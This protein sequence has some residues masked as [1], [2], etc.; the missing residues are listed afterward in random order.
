MRVWGVFFALWCLLAPAVFPASEK[1]PH[2]LYDAIKALR[3]DTSNVYRIAPA[4]HIQLRRGDAV[5][6]FDEGTVTFFFPLAGQITGA[7]FSGR[8]HVLA[9]PRDPVEKQQMGRFLGAPVLDQEFINGYLRFTDD[10]AGELLRQF[11]AANLAVQTDAS[12]G[13]QWDAALTQLNPSYTLRILFDRLSPAP[14]PVFTPGLKGRPPVRSMWCLT[15]NVTSNSSSDK[16][17]KP[18]AKLF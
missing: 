12:V 3:I 6:S 16:F 4:N 17:T 5:L 9:A 13:A 11:S 7:V 10:T 2:A 1:S 14:S 18:A 15:H 8:G